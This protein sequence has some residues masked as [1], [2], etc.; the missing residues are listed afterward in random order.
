SGSNKSYIE[1]FKAWEPR[2]VIWECNYNIFH[3]ENSIITGLG[4]YNTKDLLLECYDK[5][6]EDPEKRNYF[7]NSNFNPHNQFFDFFLSS[8]LIPGFLF[9]SLLFYLLSNYRHSFFKLSLGVSIFIFAF[10]ECFFQR[11]LGASIFALIFILIVFQISPND[12]SE[13]KIHEKN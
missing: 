3:N 4:F 9:V 6:I 11:Q 2:V 12:Q 5:Q 7:I 13:V 1:L 10:I 8:G